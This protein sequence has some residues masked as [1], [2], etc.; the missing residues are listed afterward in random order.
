MTAVQSDQVTE[1]SSDDCAFG[2]VKSA[3]ET[4][5]KKTAW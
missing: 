2:A 1:R 4:T 5:S 3:E